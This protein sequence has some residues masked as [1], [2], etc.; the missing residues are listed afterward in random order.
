MYIIKLI[1][2]S[3]IKVFQEIW[4]IYQII[5]SS[6][7]KKQYYYVKLFIVTFFLFDRWKIHLTLVMKVSHYAKYRKVTGGNYS[8]HIHSP[9]DNKNSLTYNINETTWWF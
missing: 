2:K 4:K 5:I 1:W 8:S 9:K 7:K 6:Y 3:Y